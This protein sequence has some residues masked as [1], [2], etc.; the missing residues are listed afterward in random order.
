M[1]SETDDPGPR[2]F[3]AGRNDSVFPRRGKMLKQQ[4]N[5]KVGLLN[6]LCKFAF[7]DGTRIVLPGNVVLLV[8]PPLFYMV[9]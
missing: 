9:W 1:G 7:V 3:V 5:R 4:E 2:G 8:K 6:R